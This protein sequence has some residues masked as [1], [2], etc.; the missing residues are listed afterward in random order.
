MKIGMCGVQ[1]LGSDFLK[2]F[3]LH[4]GVESVAVA[5]QYNTPRQRALVRASAWPS[6]TYPWLALAIVGVLYYKFALFCVLYGTG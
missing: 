2:L 1:G 4:P 5:D 6:G 3:G